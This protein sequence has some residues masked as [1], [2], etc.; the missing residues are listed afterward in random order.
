MHRWQKDIGKAA[1]QTMEPEFVVNI[2]YRSLPDAQFC[3]RMRVTD[4]MDVDEEGWNAEDCAEEVQ[5]GETIGVLIKALVGVR[6][7]CPDCRFLNPEPVLRH[8]KGFL[9][10]LERNCSRPCVIRIELGHVALGFY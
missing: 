6:E 10:E 1:R 3:W 8:A 9:D 5:V 2:G 7:P 4:E